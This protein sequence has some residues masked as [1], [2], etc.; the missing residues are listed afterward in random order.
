M[1][2]QVIFLSQSYQH[3]LLLLREQKRSHTL[4][5]V[6]KNRATDK[7]LFVVLFT[8]YLKADVNEDGSLREG[9]EGGKPLALLSEADKQR[10]EAAKNG[11]T[12]IPSA[13]NVKAEGKENEKTS[14]T[15]DDDVD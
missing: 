5:Y 11:E 15:N 8:L 2:L 14:Y 3:S 4:R 7:V 6:L 9:V 10:Y 1:L 12:P 13:A